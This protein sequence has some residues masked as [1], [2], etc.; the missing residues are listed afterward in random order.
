[1]WTNFLLAYRRGHYA[2]FGGRSTRAEFWSFFLFYWIITGLFGALGMILIAWDWPAAA[3]VLAA[4]YSIFSL[5]SILPYMCLTVR[6]LRDAGYSPYWLLAIALLQVLVNGLGE[7]LLD[8][9]GTLALLLSLVSLGLTLLLLGL[10]AQ[11]TRFQQA[12]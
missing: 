5:A 3:L 1:M 8:Y 6:R 11:P 10:C 2:T 9:S 4:V 7:W 12:G